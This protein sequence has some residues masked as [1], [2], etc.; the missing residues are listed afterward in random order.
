MKT[1][2]ALPNS[3][4]DGNNVGYNTKMEG[5]LNLN[6]DINK[7]YAVPCQKSFEG[8]KSCQKGYGILKP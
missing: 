5:Y 6:P 7:L 4:I 1:N 2:K 3:S 8:E